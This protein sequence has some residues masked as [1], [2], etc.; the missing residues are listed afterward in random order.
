M[1]TT[2]ANSQTFTRLSVLSTKTISLA[3][4][5]FSDFTADFGASERGVRLRCLS[6]F[7]SIYLPKVLRYHRKCM[8]RPK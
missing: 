5:M 3:L 6:C 1:P 2:S 8:N 7:A 4:S